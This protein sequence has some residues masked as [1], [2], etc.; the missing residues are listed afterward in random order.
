MKTYYI[1]LQ[2]DNNFPQAEAILKQ[3]GFMCSVMTTPDWLKKL[4]FSHALWIRT[5][6]VSSNVKML[7]EKALPVGNV[8][9][10]RSDGFAEE[11]AL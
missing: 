1:T 7:Q 2:S 8:Y 6:D 5:E 9:L 4:G 10:Q 11:L 3:E